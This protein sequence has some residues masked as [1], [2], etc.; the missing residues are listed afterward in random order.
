MIPLSATSFKG[1]E[2]KYVTECIESGWVS[3]AGPFVGR[4]EDEISRYLD[5]PSAVACVNGTAAL[6]TSLL[7]CGVL[8]GEEVIVPTLTFIAPINTVRYVGAEPVFMDCDDAL[9]LD[10]EKLS[11]FL[12]KDCD[13]ADGGVRHRRTGRLIR[14]IIVVHVFGNL[15]DLSSLMELADRYGLQVIEDATESLGSYYNNYQGKKRQAGTIGRLGCLSFNGNKIITCGGG[16][17]IVTQE[18]ELADRARHLTTQAKQDHRYYRHDLVGY[19]YRL[20]GLQAAL[21]VAQMEQLDSFVKIKRLNFQK[22][23]EALSDCAGVSLID[24]P[25][26][27]VSNFWHYALNVDHP[28]LT[29]DDLSDHLKEKGVETRPVW[30]LTHTQKPYQKEF[31]YRIEKAKRFEKQILNIPCSVTLTDE[32]IQKVSSLIKDFCG[33][34]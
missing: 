6:H 24:E 15:A 14:A 33:K 18:K 22:Y 2:L 19:N 32:E 28:R 8:P 13:K 23:R 9:N 27:S 12:E 30:A 11:D 10:P 21:G 5:I 16:G 7:L 17:M 31:A 29:R 34:N 25:S 1:N 26:Y 20:T 4:F 3:S